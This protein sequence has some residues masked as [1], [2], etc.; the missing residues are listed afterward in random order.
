M[1]HSLQFVYRGLAVLFVMFV[2]GPVAV[3]Q[4]LAGLE[5]GI[6]PY[7][8][9]EGGDIDSV[10]MVNGSLTLHMPLISYPQRGGKLRVGFSLIYANPM[11]QPWAV[12]NPYA[13]TCSSSGYNVVYGAPRRRLDV[14]SRN[15]RGC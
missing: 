2:F 4:N 3:A 5:Q 10:S 12:C 14:L 6:K 9:Y 8:S 15:K 11:L 13:H 7:G 1:P